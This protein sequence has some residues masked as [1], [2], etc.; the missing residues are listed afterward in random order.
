MNRTTLVIMAAGMGSRFGKGIKQ[1]EHVGP[2]GEILMDYSIY[3][4][5]KAGF[6]KIVIVIRKDIEDEFKKLIG[7]RIAKHVNME[8]VYQDIDDLPEG[9]TK[10]ADRTKPWGT[11]HAILSA[12]K[13]VDTPF[14]VINA[15]DFYGREAFVKMHDYLAALSDDD[16]QDY[17][18]AG[19]ILGN[20]LS[21]NGTVTRGICIHDDDYYLKTVEESFELRLENGVVV[22][23]DS[24]GNDITAPSDALVSM[25]MWG[26]KPVY[27]KQ[28]Q[29]DFVSFLE[30]EGDPLKKEFLL[31]IIMDNLIKQ[32]KA[33]IKI[34]PVS[35]RWFGLTYIA[36]KPMIVE[37]LNKIIEEGVYPA[38]LWG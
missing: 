38:N 33:K 16:E 31:P 23:K 27:F 14:A 30:S 32:G 25:N 3:D 35:E 18:M 37:K 17:C 22:G 34:L 11:G 29:E 5:A 26:C 8:Y 21:D 1:L 4:A 10:P 28:L 36:D 15:D 13:A 19:Y 20:T 24:K 2:S 6:D 9:F 12:A 7:D